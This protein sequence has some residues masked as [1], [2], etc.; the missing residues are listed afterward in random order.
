MFTKKQNKSQKPGNTCLQE[1]SLGT[2]S[3]HVEIHSPRSR[4]FSPRISSTFR[5]GRRGKLPVI[6]GD[7]EGSR[8]PRGSHSLLVSGGTAEGDQGCA[9]PAR[10][11]QAGRPKGLAL[12][13]Q[14]PRWT[15]ASQPSTSVTQGK[16]LNVHVILSLFAWKW[17]AY[18]IGRL[19][20]LNESKQRI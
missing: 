1:R 2:D 19:W 7:E 3:G 14:V 8:Q 11:V 13:P 4:C 18:L 16:V 17:G 6:S 9:S 5:V 15:L 20:E 10:E 12:E